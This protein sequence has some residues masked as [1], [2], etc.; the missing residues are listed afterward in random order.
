MV[1]ENNRLLILHVII[2][3]LL[4]KYVSQ[5]Y[6]FSVHFVNLAC[7][8][9]NF[10]LLH[11]II[12]RSIAIFRSIFPHKELFLIQICHLVVQKG[13]IHGLNY[14]HALK[15]SNPVL[16]GMNQLDS[17]YLIIIILVVSRVIKNFLAKRKIYFK[18][19]LLAISV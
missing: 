11:F 15:L 10:D 14:A 12:E 4:S 18:Y 17:K 2:L 5:S 16:L 6:Q 13:E 9:W 1:R 8:I 3:L 7:S 19:A